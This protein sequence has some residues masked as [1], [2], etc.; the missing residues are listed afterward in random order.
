MNNLKAQK[1]KNSYKELLEAIDAKGLSVE[2][3][4][5]WVEDYKA[6]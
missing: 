6:E 2:E 3:V 1:S 5:K 4:I